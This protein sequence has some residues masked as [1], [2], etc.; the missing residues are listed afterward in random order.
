[1]T[2][3]QKMELVLFIQLFVHQF[4]NLNIQILI[5][6]SNLSSETKPTKEKKNFLPKSESSNA[7]SEFQTVIIRPDP[8]KEKK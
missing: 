6:S 3:K 1:M 8:I 2:L 5:S 7:Y 4:S